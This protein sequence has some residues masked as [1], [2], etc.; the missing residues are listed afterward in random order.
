L[1]YEL[2]NYG[3]EAMHYLWAAHPQF[4]ADTDTIIKLPHRITQVVNVLD[5]ETWGE[6]GELYSWPRAVS[7]NGKQWQ[8]DRIGQAVY[9]DCRKFYLPAEQ[10]I[11]WAELVN[12]RVGCSMHMDWNVEDLPYFGLWVDEGAFNAL[13]AVAPEPSN[14]YYDSLALAYR[15]KRVGLIHPGEKESWSLTVRLVT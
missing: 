8:L 11:V 1:N 15:N 6:T 7:K 2:E 9:K 5:S 12:P 14:G 13:P 4:I 3:V 10:S